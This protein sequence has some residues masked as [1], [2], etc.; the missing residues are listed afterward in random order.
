MEGAGFELRWALEPVLEA[1]I[2]VEKL[3]MVG[4]AAQSEIWPSILSSITGIPICI[5][6]YDQWPA[7]GAAIL[8]G[9]G[10]NVFS[11]VQNGLK[12][13]AKSEKMYYPE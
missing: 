8:A 6:E 10:A 12:V 5:P 9:V 3:W 2:P 7:V 13:F 4:G 11:D 1:G